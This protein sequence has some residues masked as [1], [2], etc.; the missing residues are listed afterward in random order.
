MK[1]FGFTLV[2]L[3]VLIGVIGIILSLT[4]PAVQNVRARANAN[5]CMINLREI[6]LGLHNY[7]ASFNHLPPG[8]PTP[9]LVKYK[10]PNVFLSWR[11]HLCP[12]LEQESRYNYAI[13]DTNRGIKP[14]S[15]PLPSGLSANLKVFQ[16]PSDPS[17]GKN[18]V[19][20]SGFLVGWSSYLG[21]S[22]GVEYQQQKST[23]KSGIFAETTILKK[24]IN[25]SEVL[26]GLSNTL[27]VGER[28]PPDNGSAGQWYFTHRGI[29]WENQIDG[30]DHTLDTYS[31]AVGRDPCGPAGFGP[32]KKSNPCDRNHFWSLH[33]G[34]SYFS[35]GDGSVKFLP[36]SM[37]PV[38]AKFASRAGGEAVI[39][40]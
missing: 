29:L 36:Y 21:V 18:I 33:F 9:N 40:D 1:R 8:S 2:E 20:S 13:L 6:S 28:P 7:H 4:I 37:K 15:S 19:D 31:Y 30:P 22:G 10:D 38:L 11:V 12:Y 23:T 3:L 34:G 5:S 26:D 16:C 24:G 17:F 39:L 27:M 35:L 32:G 25:F 14:F